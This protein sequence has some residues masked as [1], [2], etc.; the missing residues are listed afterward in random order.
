MRT[1]LENANFVYGYAGMK[2]EEGIYEDINCES[3]EVLG[4]KMGGKV[5]LNEPPKSTAKIGIIISSDKSYHTYVNVEESERGQEE[6]FGL[7]VG[8]IN[9]EV[10]AQIHVI[11]EEREKNSVKSINGDGNNCA[12]SDDGKP[13]EE[14]LKDN[15][16][17]GMEKGRKL[18]DSNNENDTDISDSFA[19]NVRR[20]IEEVEKE[21]CQGDERLE[22][23]LE[24]L[25]EGMRK[26]REEGEQ[27]DT[28]IKHISE[29]TPRRSARLVGKQS[30]LVEENNKQKK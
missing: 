6:G 23:V 14:G 20:A 11:S 25:E 19:E 10:T 30:K 12:A 15:K 24:S 27:I 5:A 2:E 8:D 7:D 3:S 17:E 28:R 4:K 21:R 13:E 9:K 26:E 22:R 16:D 29:D 1:G 18:E